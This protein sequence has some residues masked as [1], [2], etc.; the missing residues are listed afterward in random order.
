MQGT[1]NIALASLMSDRLRAGTDAVERSSKS[2]M[3]GKIFP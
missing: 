1:G 2:C 3:R